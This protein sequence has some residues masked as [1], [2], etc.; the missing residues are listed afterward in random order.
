LQVLSITKGGDKMRVNFITLHRVLNYG[1]VLQTYATCKL[2]ESINVNDIEVIDYYREK[3]YDY[4]RIL[5]YGSYRTRKEHGAK[6]ILKKILYDMMLKKSVMKFYKACDSFL[7]DNVKLSSQKYYSEIDLE[8]NVNRCDIMCVGSDQVWNNIHNE[9]I[10]WPFFLKFCHEGT[11]KVSFSSSLGIENPDEEYA[12]ILYSELNKFDKL[13]VREK[14]TQQML[15]SVGIKSEFI[16]DPTLLYKKE[17]WQELIHERNIKEKYLLIYQFGNSKEINKIAKKVAKEKGLI[18]VNIVFHPHQVIGRPGK[19]IV[20]PT[21]EEFL[22]LLFYADFVVTNSFHGTSFS[23]NFEKN[24]I[25]VLRKDFNIRMQS[26]LQTL[27]LDNRIY[28]QE[29][30]KEIIGNE[31]D[32]NKANEVL[33]F[34]RKEAIEW[35][36]GVFADEK[37]S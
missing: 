7:C 4:Q 34:K 27:H 16:I 29:K 11:K 32:Y 3:D 12:K 2:L 17:Q 6:K 5:N 25:V 21:V 14:Q 35:L 33:S 30:E 26:I 8:K 37:S 36:R 23:I 9:G 10:E 1:S 20:V 13:S 18:I 15:N 28:I 19:K 24:F 31:I 22:N